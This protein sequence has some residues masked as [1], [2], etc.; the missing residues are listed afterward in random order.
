M[1]HACSNGQ[2]AEGEVV[3]GAELKKLLFILNLWSLDILSNDP[4]FL[5][6]FF[7]ALCMKNCTGVKT[8]LSSVHSCGNF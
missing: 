1:K 2:S 7:N 8:D 3:T 6:S 5:S 4:I